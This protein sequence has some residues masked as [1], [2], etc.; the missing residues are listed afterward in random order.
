MQVSPDG[1]HV[2]V[3]G[4]DGQTITVFGATTDQHNILANKWVELV[5]E[6]KSGMIWVGSRGGLTKYNPRRGVFTPFQHVPDDPN[7]LSNDTV[8]ALI[9]DLRN[10]L[11]VGTFQGL[12]R[13]DRFTNE[14]ER[15]VPDD[16]SLIGLTSRITGFIQD[17]SGLLWIS[18]HQGLF[19]YDRKSGL[20]FN[21]T[22]E[23]LIREKTAI[24]TMTYG[25]ECIWLWIEGGMVRL[26][27]S[28]LGEHQFVPFETEDPA[29]YISRIQPDDL[30]QIWIQTMDGLYC[31]RGPDQDVVRVLDAGGTTHS[32]ALNPIEPLMKDME[33]FI[34]Y[35]TFGDGIYKIDPADFSFK[36]FIHNPADPQSLSENSINC[37]F[38]D[39]SGTTWIGTFG[40][41]ISILNPRENRF[42]LFK[43]NPFN[44]NS[45][46][47]SFIWT[48]CETTDS[49]LWF[50][51][52]E[53][54]SSFD[55][56]NWKSYTTREGLIHNTVHDIEVDGNGLVWFATP[57]GISSFD[58]STWTNCKYRH[59]V[60]CD[61]RSSSCAA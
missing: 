51:T 46:A 8:S 43:H 3:A 49:T 26:D 28:L 45:L 2:Y 44:T 1:K 18:T 21:E 50:G 19:S 6:D 10:E 58:G 11:W 57:A 14:V 20:F 48:I 31:Y 59:K 16:S 23:D 7:S 32:L 17:E 24:Y 53:G 5:Y 22:A 56:M 12:N 38:Q 27:L 39:R 60:A 33:G 55:G 25:N 30:G 4:D 47:S 40:A 61:S 15:I 35:G 13:V 37:I 9:A 36:H 52:P 42:T 34:W 41:G 29:A 54:A